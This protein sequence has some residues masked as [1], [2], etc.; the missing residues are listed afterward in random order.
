MLPNLSALKRNSVASLLALSIAAGSAAPASALG[1]NERK[2]LQGAA[3]AAIIGA[4]L[5]DNDRRN[6]AIPAP[7]APP[8]TRQ[9]PAPVY[10]PPPPVYQQPIPTQPVYGKVIGHDH[11]RAPHANSIYASPAAQAFNSYNL[12]ERRAIQRRLAAYG[13]YRSGIDGD[14]GPGTYS[15]IMAYARDSGTTDRLSSR[16]T[17]FA[18]LDGLIF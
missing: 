2:F 7:V 3:A 11:H 13:Y 12:T 15:A 18:V 1:K 14:F 16:N 10:A 8:V 9:P 17:A 5:Y 4:L 6:R